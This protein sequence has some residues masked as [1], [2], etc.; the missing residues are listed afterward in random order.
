MGLTPFAVRGVY[1]GMKVLV[2]R[3]IHSV[4]ENNSSILLRYALLLSA[5]TLLRPVSAFAGD[6]TIL[7]IEIQSAW[8]GLGSPQATG[9]VIHHEKGEYHLG[10]TRVDSASVESLRASI[11]QPAHRRPTLENLGLTDEWLK[12]AADKLGRDAEHND[13]SDSVLYKLGHGRPDQKA[14][15]HR[16]YTDPHFMARVLPALFRCCHTDDYPQV[17]VSI[18]YADGNRTTLSSDS[19]SEF[20]LPWKVEGSDGT[21]ETYNKNISIAV[22]A[23]LPEKAANR[24]RI[25]GSGLDLAL[26]WVVMD[27]IEN[28]WNLSNAKARAGEALARIGRFTQSSAQISI[29]I[30]M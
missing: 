19:Q 18:L 23:I 26:A 27:A 12:N 2:L 3:K 16:S 21:A 20:M 9:L 29:P 28:D 1:T 10:S 14:I 30:T 6:P 24:E 22:A 7:Q 4:C 17:K 25:S 8:G 13:G 5:F 11:R 15:F